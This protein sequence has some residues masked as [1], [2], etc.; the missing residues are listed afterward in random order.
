MPPLL[1]TLLGSLLLLSSLQHAPLHSV[2]ATMA[3]NGDTLVV[4]QTLA[5]DDKLIS[6]NSKFALGFF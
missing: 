4:G 3:V 6:R 2:I 5:A 1:Y